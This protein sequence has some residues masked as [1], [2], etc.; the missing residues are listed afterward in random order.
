MP[1][2][3]Y[4]ISGGIL[5]RIIHDGNSTVGNCPL[6]DVYFGGAMSALSSGFEG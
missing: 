6:L 1:P 3:R 4:G 2:D 5:A